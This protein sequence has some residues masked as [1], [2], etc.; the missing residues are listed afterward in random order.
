MSNHNNLNW[1]DFILCLGM[2][3]AWG[4]DPVRLQQV[5]D[6]MGIGFNGGD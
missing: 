1:T 2:E 6:A 3:L 4:T 5:A